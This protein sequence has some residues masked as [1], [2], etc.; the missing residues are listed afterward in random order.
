LEAAVLYSISNIDIIKYFDGEALVKIEVLFTGSH[1]HFQS[2]YYFN[3]DQLVFARKNKT[4]FHK[5]KLH[6]DFDA[7]KKSILN[8]NY[9]FYDE[10][11]AMWCN[12]ESQPES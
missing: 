1:E 12:G 4:I 9:Y 2:D 10:H 7:S 8:N 3:K 6:K 5:S 11:L